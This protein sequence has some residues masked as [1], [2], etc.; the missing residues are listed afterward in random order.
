MKSKYNILTQDKIK[1]SYLLYPILF[2]LGLNPSNKGTIYLKK[3]I[4]YIIL[5]DLY[6]Y[7]Y[8]EILQLFV[9]TN[10][11]KLQ[12]TKNNIKNSLYRIDYIKI[13][14]NFELVFLLKYECE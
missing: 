11:Y 4:E 10:N 9:N 7:S 1:V 14:K 2:E 6:D 13:K 5:N 12:K 3:I 8:K